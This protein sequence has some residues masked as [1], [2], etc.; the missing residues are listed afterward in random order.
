MKKKLKNFKE[1]LSINPN[2]KTNAEYKASCHFLMEEMFG[3]DKKGRRRSYMWIKERFKVE[4]HFSKI[5]DRDLL[6]KIFDILWVRS[7]KLSAHYGKLSWHDP[8]TTTSRWKQPL[9]PKKLLLGK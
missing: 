6:K 1:I 4:I 9:P 7:F 3:A 8:R 5:N 2:P